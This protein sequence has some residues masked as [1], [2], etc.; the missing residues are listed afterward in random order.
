MTEESDSEIIRQV[1]ALPVGVVA[2]ATYPLQALLFIRKH[3]QLWGC[4]VIPILVNLVIG[5]V[6]YAGLLLPGWRGI[7]QWASGVP[8][9]LAQWVASLPSW[10]SRLLTWLPT[11]ATFFDDVL[12]FLMAIAL[13]V[14]TGLLL[15]QFGA[16][17]GAPWYGNLAEQTERLRRG[18]LPNGS[19]SFN[20]ALQDIWRALTF[21][22]KK[23][24]L[25]IV[26]G[27]PF[28]VLNFLPPLG[29]TIA[30]VGGVALAALMVGLDFLDAPLER[31]RL[32]FRQKLG[33]FAR[34]L[35]AS[36]TFSWACLVL[37]SIPLISLLAVPICVAA[38]TL[39]CCDRVLPYLPADEASDGSLGKEPE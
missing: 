22:L 16:I 20:R 4:V 36:A 9:W 32:S 37:V 5:A 11:G 10:A 29:T 24:V 13:F 1:G 21:Q 3:S 6:L 15:V 30:S 28:L 19:P 38:G 7:D 12:R 2:G 33:V 18:Q 25:L 14:L 26:F 39:F 27:L 31:R 23:L 8:V 35:P 17:L 34:S